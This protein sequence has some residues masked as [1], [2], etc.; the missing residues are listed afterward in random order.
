M[1]SEGERENHPLARER[2]GKDHKTKT[3]LRQK[4]MI[5]GREGEEEEGEGEGHATW[6]KNLLTRVRVARS[7]RI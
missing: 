4:E 6:R 2:D 3:T 5:M 7:S 1:S